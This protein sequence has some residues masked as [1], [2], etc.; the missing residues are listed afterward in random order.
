MKSYLEASSVPAVTVGRAQVPRLVM[1]IHPYDGCSYQDENRD[2]ENLKAF[3][4]VGQVVE[5]LRYTVEEHGITSAQVD[6]MLPDLDRL[7]LQA[8]WETE[9]A[10]QTRIGLLPY[11]LIPV[12]LDGKIV[13][14]S[15]RAHATFYTHDERLG[16]AA[17]RDKLAEDEILR[18]TLSGSI[19]NL[20][21]PEIAAP[22]S[23][24][25]A[26]RMAIDYGVLEQYLGFFAGCEVMVAD[27]GAEIDLLA[28]LGRFDLIREYIAFLRGRY[29]T[30]ITS[31]HHAGVTIPLL[32]EMNI[33]VDAY[34]TPVNRLGY[35]M[36]PTRDLALGAIRNAKQPVIA[37][38]AMAG[39]RYLGH[40]AFEFV[41]NEVDVASCLFG[42]G[43]LEQVKQTATAARE[44][45]AAAA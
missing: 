13:S 14:Y 36:F 8:V 20:V 45:L 21:T 12:T 15:P 33:D 32:E 17:F 9:Q 7:H 3:S 29:E 31:V 22:Y 2:A 26:A 5:V 42:M 25:E 38:K 39:G 18:Y 40:P 27:P 16:G 6:H 34:L 30:V 4:T 43:K 1:G 10:T 28:M 11:I 44:V 35:Y 23:E 37:I 19:D 24:E 41:F